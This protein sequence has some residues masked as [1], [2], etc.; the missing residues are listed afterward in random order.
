MKV[1]INGGEKEISAGMT[2]KEL[3]QSLSLKAPVTVVEINGRI[4]SREEFDSRNIRVNDVIELI[5]FVGGG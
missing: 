2:V 5:R 4:L 3:L 1:T